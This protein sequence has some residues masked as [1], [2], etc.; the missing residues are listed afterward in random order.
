MEIETGP[1][2]QF[3]VYHLMDL[4]PGQERLSPAA[5]SQGGPSLISS[6]VAVLGKDPRPEAEHGASFDS[7]PYRAKSSDTNGK[8]ASRAAIDSSQGQNTHPKEKLS[9]ISRVLRSKNAGPYEITMDIMFESDS[10]FEAVRHSG[11]LS[12]E[13][14]AK[15][16][17]IPEE[18][19]IWLGF[20]A[21]ALAFKVTIPRFRAGKKVSAGSFMENDIHGSQQHRGL[22]DIKLP[23]GFAA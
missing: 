13:N 23:P 9:D 17:D 14:V 15:A 4:D 8:K 16:L 3:S 11:L 1:C 20:F 2:A 19:I 6:K 7:N 5:L 10:T 22:S 21:P 12:P 18:E